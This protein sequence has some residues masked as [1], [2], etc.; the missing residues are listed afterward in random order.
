MQ[1]CEC[2]NIWQLKEGDFYCS[3][4]GDELLKLELPSKIEYYYVDHD[5]PEDGS[6]DF[7][8]KNVG[9]IPAKI[10]ILLSHC[11][12]SYTK[13]GKISAD[14][15]QLQVGQTIAFHLPFNLDQVNTRMAEVLLKVI[16]GKCHKDITFR[17]YPT[18]KIEV[19]RNQFTAIVKRNQVA[20]IILPIYAEFAPVRLK[21]IEIFGKGKKLH[22][23]N[24]E[25]DISIGKMEKTLNG[26]LLKRGIGMPVAI[27]P[28]THG[29]I[30]LKLYAEG[31]INPFA[32]NA[33]I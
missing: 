29:E 3:F 18:P 4:C 15:V 14:D 32:F 11:Y 17:I 9:K 30:S 22:E 25:Y 23:D 28:N 12:P 13:L 27:P 7:E 26:E 1:T 10:S 31:L 8:I 6:I 33:S 5:K 19:L 20:N 2:C 21:K 24:L 16:C